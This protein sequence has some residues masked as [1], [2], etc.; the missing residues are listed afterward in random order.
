[1]PL[2]L[3]DDERAQLAKDLAAELDTGQYGSRFVLSRRQL[4]T[5]AG[6]SA[7]V[8]GLVALGVD[9]AT[10]QSAAGQVG[11]Q[12]SPEDVFAFDL[13]VQGALQRDLD[14]GGQAITNAGSVS[15]STITINS[16]VRYVSSDTELDDALA[17]ANGGDMIILGNSTYTTDRTISK[18]LCFMG[19]HDQFGAVID[20]SWTVDGRV[21]IKNTGF[22]GGNVITINAVNSAIESCSGDATVTVFAD[23]FRYL[24]NVGG[25]ITFES[26]ASGGIVDGC[27]G[28]TITDNGSNQIGDVA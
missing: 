18:D 3:T 1:M 9:P 11:T 10:A 22:S 23:D 25:D 17:S 8:A 16:T 6:G 12:S 19:S 5:L 24:N 13:D 27:A 14:A 21:K 26:G 2:D 20:S 7:G 28:T 15:T 4:L